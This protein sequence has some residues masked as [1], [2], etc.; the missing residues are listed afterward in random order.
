MPFLS[1]LRVELLNDRAVFPWIV[2]EP[3]V[4]ESPLTG[5]VYTVPRHF[6]TDGASVPE[7]LFAVPVV[8]PILSMRFFGHGV[9]QGFKQGVLHDYLRRGPVRPVA[10]S[11]AH[12]V[13]REALYD[14]GYPEDL[15]ENYYAAVKRFNSKD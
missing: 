10:A 11:V 9:W 2:L 5:E 3:L 12:L 7:A 14:G 13:F 1:P 6:V 8:G 15:V 4:Y